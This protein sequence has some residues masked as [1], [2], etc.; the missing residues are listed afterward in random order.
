[1]RDGVACC[2]CVLIKKNEKKKKKKKR[3]TKRKKMTDVS[4]VELLDSA[5]SSKLLGS[6]PLAG[7]LSAVDSVFVLRLARLFGRVLMRGSRA[8]ALLLT[9]LV[10]MVCGNEALVFFVGMLPSELIA[11]LINRS[12]AAFFSVLWKAALFTTGEAVLLSM[13]AWLTGTLALCWRDRLVSA[14]HGKYLAGF[15]FFTANQALDNSDQRIVQDANLMTLTLVKIFKASA[16]P[17]VIAFY[18]YRVWSMLGWIGPVSIYS[19]FVLGSVANKFL[20]TRLSS[21]VF[22]QERVEGDFRFSHARLRS[23]AEEI[24]LYRGGHHE[25]SVLDQAFEAVLANMKVV[26][27]RRFALDVSTNLFAYVGGFLS[28][29]VVGIAM[30]LGTAFDSVED[31]AQFAGM[32]QQSSFLVIMLTYGF[33]QIVQLSSDVSDLSGF[34]N[35]VAELTE[36]LDRIHLEEFDSRLR[37]RDGP[38][39]FDNVTV[40]MPSSPMPLVKNLSFR[41]EQGEG[42]LISG[43]SGSGKTSIVRLLHGLWQLGPG[44]G[45]ISCPEDDQMCIVPQQPYLVTGSLADQ[46]TYPNTDMTRR[47]GNSSFAISREGLEEDLSRLFESVGL[48]YFLQRFSVSDVRDWDTMLSPGERQKLSIAR[49]LFHKPLFCVLDESTSAMSLQDEKLMYNLIAEAGISVISIS[50]RP[51]LRD[52]H[53]H[54][55]QLEGDGKWKLV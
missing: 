34:T 49:V 5:E 12:S 47:G 29:V 23:N 35:R 20:M 1:M 41:V 53:K 28:Y 14:L 50:H 2:V 22:R 55:L 32:L 3:K 24:A 21:F 52:W 15:R 48:G 45:K 27:S 6:R 43:P 33:S 30:Q 54:N 10:A 19:Y 31:P 11:G 26:L 25:Q 7:Q 9:A 38:I 37:M 39:V 51:S 36:E 13:I 44:K 42:M 17:F 46:I 16:V 18:T 8:P 40:E 4:D